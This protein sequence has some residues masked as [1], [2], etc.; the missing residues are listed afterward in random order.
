MHTPSVAGPLV[1]VLPKF[2]KGWL[3]ACA[4]KDAGPKAQHSIVGFA[5]LAIK[6][7]DHRQ[8]P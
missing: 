2:G 8:N 1:T 4:I 5:G 6:D 7:E 3:R